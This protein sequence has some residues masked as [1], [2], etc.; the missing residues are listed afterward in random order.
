VL[1]VVAVLGGAV[2]VGDWLARSAEMDRLVAGIEESEAAMIAAMGAVRAALDDDSA[3]EG[4]SQATAEALQSIAAEG[5]AAVAQA[6]TGIAAV[7]IQ[8]WHDDVLLAQDRYL[9]HNQAWQEFLAAAAEEPERWF[10]EYEPITTTWDAFGP[11]LR[12]AVP[13]PA[14]WDVAER[15]EVILDDDSGDSGNGSVQQAAG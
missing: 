12:S 10:V 4:L 2:L 6:A 11:A 9:E 3:A 1:V 13:T 14:L 5:E 8:P 15:V 7:V